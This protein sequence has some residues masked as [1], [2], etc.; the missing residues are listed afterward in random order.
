MHEKDPIVQKFARMPGTVL[1]LIVAS[2]VLLKIREGNW[3]R[4]INR[5]TRLNQ[6]NGSIR[7]VRLVK[8]IPNT[9]V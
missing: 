1:D 7:F 8:I 5:S 6:M 4:K 3:D 2:A 9:I